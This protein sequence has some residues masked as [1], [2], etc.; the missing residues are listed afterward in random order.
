[1]DIFNHNMDVKIRLCQCI[2]IY[3]ILKNGFLIVYNYIQRN[4][5]YIIQNSKW[6]NM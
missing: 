3:F 6:E 1:M 2:L 4:K 5:L